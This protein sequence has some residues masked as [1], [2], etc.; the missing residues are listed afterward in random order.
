MLSQLFYLEKIGVVYN[1]F[2][3]RW[4]C[5]V[6]FSLVFECVYVPKNPHH[7]RE[8]PRI[9]ENLR[10][11]PRISENQVNL[12]GYRWCLLASLV[13]VQGRCLSVC[14]DPLK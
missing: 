12:V 1:V 14:F 2:D 5:L 8:S 9:S 11:S 10:E 13:D 7:S 4:L 6:I 3:S